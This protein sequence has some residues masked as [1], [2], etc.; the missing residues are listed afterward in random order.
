LEPEVVR[1]I[2]RVIA[3]CHQA[4]SRHDGGAPLYQQAQV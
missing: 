2:C 1:H 4:A 3:E